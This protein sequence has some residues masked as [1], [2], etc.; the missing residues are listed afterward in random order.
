[1]DP[2]EHVAVHD[3]E[4]EDGLSWELFPLR[5]PFLPLRSIAG[6]DKNTLFAA[7]TLEVKLRQNWER[8]FQSF[9]KKNP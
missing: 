7:V 4:Y 2:P 1:M 9:C 3:P 8:K 5:C 6:P